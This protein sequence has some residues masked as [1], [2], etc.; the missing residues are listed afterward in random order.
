MRVGW[1]G[2]LGDGYQSDYIGAD[3]DPYAI[4]DA[5]HIASNVRS[6]GYRFSAPQR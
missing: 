5:Q 1:I 4:G 3:I 6:L 2:V